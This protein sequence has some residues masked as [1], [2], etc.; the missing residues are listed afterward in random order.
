MSDSFLMVRC[1]LCIWTRMPSE[2]C[3]SLLSAFIKRH[4]MSFGP[5]IGDVNFG[6]QVNVIPAKVY[7]FSLEINKCSVN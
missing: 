2:C 3:C 1:S 4:R 7:F 6:H 5:T